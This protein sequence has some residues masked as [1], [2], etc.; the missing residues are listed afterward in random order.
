MQ[1][2]F[3][4]QDNYTQ[5]NKKAIDTL[6]IYSPAQLILKASVATQKDDEIKQNIYYNYFFKSNPPDSLKFEAYYTMAYDFYTYTDYGVDYST[7]LMK[8]AQV[9]AKKTND[10]YSKILCLDGLCIFYGMQNET[11]KV[12]ESLKEM[13]VLL[14]EDKSL[15]PLKKLHLQSVPYRIYFIIGDFKRSTEGYLKAN[16]NIRNYIA[17]NPNLSPD[18][19]VN[20]TYDIKSNYSRLLTN[21]NYQKKLDSSAYYLKKIKK[22][23]QNGYT[24]FIDIWYQETMYLILMNRTDEAIDKI[25]LLDQ[26]YLMNQKNERHKALY[27]LA[28]CYESK[29]NYKKTLEL[30]EEALTLKTRSFHFQN[31]HIEL[32]KTAANSAKQLKLE[33]K[34]SYYAEKY[35]EAVEKIDYEQKALFITKLYDQDVI[36]P[37]GHKLTTEKKFSN[38]YLFGSISLLFVSSYLV[39][40]SI[41]SDRDKKKFL[42]II[43]HMERKEA[44]AKEKE[45]ISNNSIDEFEKATEPKTSTT[46]SKTLNEDTERKILKQ[47]ANFEKKQQFISSNIT[48]GSLAADFNTNVVYLASVIKKYKNNSFNN[49]LNELRIDYIISKLKSNPEYATY[50]IAYLAAECG[51]TSH[52]AFIRVFT[53]QKGIPPSKFIKL[54]TSSN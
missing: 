36:A 43:S 47:L 3:A 52:S 10:I 14:I 48:A 15:D 38:Y 28:L 2:A 17:E 44:L 20:L 16:T 13:K 37:L 23:E 12:L 49:Y 33:K 54:L 41:R 30:C 35:L 4:Q 18:K 6:L 31:I 42:E 45:I 9:Y 19:V 53:Q 7:E 50:K 34:A 32:L 21:Y 29:K 46:I 5:N 27:C 11:E 39:W 26:K 22:L 25:A 8:K 51:F 24:S 40:R 1:D